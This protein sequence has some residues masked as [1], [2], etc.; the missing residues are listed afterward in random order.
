MLFCCCKRNVLGL[1]CTT[2]GRFL[3]IVMKKVSQSD[4]RL[5]PATKGTLTAPSSRVR[6]FRTWET[7]GELKDVVWDEI[8]LDEQNTLPSFV[9]ENFP[10]GSCAPLAFII[11]RLFFSKIIFD[12]IKLKIL[13]SGCLNLNF[14]NIRAILTENQYLQ[15][16]SLRDHWR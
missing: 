8:D 1:P 4:P 14:L 13:I 11:I 3:K 7:S 10:K 16:G 6:C 9:S 12:Y 2:R 5:H 15:E